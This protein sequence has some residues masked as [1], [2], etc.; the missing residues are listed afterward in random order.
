MVVFFVGSSAILM[1]YVSF[2]LHPVFIPYVL[3]VG[4]WWLLGAPIANDYAIGKFIP[5]NAWIELVH[6]LLIFACFWFCLSPE[7]PTRRSR[8][9]LA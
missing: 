6:G 5:S 2:R 4:A 9:A 7:G 1:R 3:Y 8:V